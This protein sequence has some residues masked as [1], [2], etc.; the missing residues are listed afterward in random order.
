[1]SGLISDEP[2]DM[3]GT[4]SCRVRIL[5][6][7]N[8]ER[9]RQDVAIN[10]QRWGYKPI[11]AEGIG[12]AL[13]HDALEKARHHRCHLALVDM[14]LKDD[15]DAS[16]TSGLD[17]VATLKPTE[18]I[19]VSAFGD[20]RTAVTA[21]K[22]KGAL[23]FVGK[24]DGPRALRYAIEKN[25]AANICPCIT[26]TAIEWP[27][28]FS[29]EWIVRLIY[30]NDFNVPPD[31]AECLLRR[32]FHEDKKLKLEYL[33]LNPRTPSFSPRPHSILLKATVPGKEPFV[34]KLARSVRIDREFEHYSN[35]VHERLP[36]RFHAQTRNKVSLWDLGG[37][38]YHFMGTHIHKFQ[39]FSEFYA[40][41]SPD[42]IKKALTHLFKD[43]WGRLYD[44]HR[45]LLGVSLFE[46]YNQLW[47]GYAVDDD[48]T[49]AYNWLHHL[50]SHLQQSQQLS[51]QLSPDL[52]PSPL[53]NP[54]HWIQSKKR[55]SRLAKTHK[56]IVHGDMLGDNIFVDPDD[57]TWVINYERTGPGP[58]LADFVEL[59]VDI[60]THL[61]Q[62]EDPSK[63]F[64]QYVRMVVAAYQPLA[65]PLDLSN[66]R[67]LANYELLSGKHEEARK[68]LSVVE[69]LRQLASSIA[70]Q[71]EDPRSY[72][73]GILFNAVFRALLRKHEAE[74]LK[75]MGNRSRI[76]IT[77]LEQI[78]FRALILGSII[79]RLLENWDNA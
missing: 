4:A 66:P 46:G 75:N 12:E 47:G 28:G 45:S 56:T 6:V 57:R 78:E 11:V 73:W 19:I 43:V 34:V 14:R 61:A 5:V 18:S 23:D 22:D 38:V 77:N 48:P 37:I 8:E 49:D 71:D 29:S 62:F 68:A 76:Q 79:C 32:L 64:E 59:E 26:G 42:K 7:E 40:K 65:H 16:D 54:V 52:F 58:I 36:H 31:E 35:Y 30:P 10:L 51:I 17:L 33:S 70:P 3:Y 39:T 74:L 1:M 41:S 60:M 9:S 21:L 72:F 63:D 25:L 55:W 50:K 69:G 27:P 20:R 67:L 53:I 15:H 24:E 44:Q 2:I 13:I